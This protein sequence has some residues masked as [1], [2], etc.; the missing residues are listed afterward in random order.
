MRRVLL[1]NSA[2]YLPGEGG[3]KRTMY[4]LD[5]MLKMGYECVLLTSDFNHYSKKKRDVSKFRNEY[6][7]YNQS[8]Q[9]LHKLPYKKNVSFKR[10]YS[11]K[12]FENSIAK[13][14]KRN[15]N[16]FDVVFASDQEAVLNISPILKK[17]KIPLVIDIRDLF[18]EALKVVLKNETI[19]KIL[20]WPFSK[21]EDKA[22]SCA[23]EIVAVSKEYLERGLKTNKKSVHPEI[24]YLGST[25]ELFDA[26]IEK[27]APEIN[28]SKDEFWISYVGTIGA[29]YDFKTIIT[30]MGRLGKK[31]PGLKF[32]VLGH[33]PY[34][35]EHKEYAKFIGADNVNFLGFMD[36]QKMA[37]YLSKTDITINNIKKNASQ[38]IINKVS[39]YFAS[40]KPMLNS[41]RNEEMQWLI[42]NFKTGLNYEAE[43]VD[44]FI[45]KFEVLYNDKDLRIEMGRNARKLAEKKFDRKNS[46]KK[47]I[48]IIENVN[49]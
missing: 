10:F 2:V 40:G 21:L 22:Y 8:I 46:Y 38:S 49:I 48:E 15:I 13:W 18:P 19:Y 6:S 33:G 36:Y 3:Y 12:K 47:I 31:Y 35:E 43:N 45:R 37:A 7:G 30:A 32:K 16:N 29:S 25:L 26:G 17:N 9:I 1:I 44:D 28:K 27:Y 14:V 42:S 34:E 11:D 5:M 24:V 23:D 41:C 20:T 39:D 4:L